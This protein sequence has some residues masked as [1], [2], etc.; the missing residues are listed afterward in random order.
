MRLFQNSGVHSSYLQRL[1]QLSPKNSGF[2]TRRRQL[3][4]DRFGALHFLKPVL[5]DDSETFFTNGDDRIL[6]Q[7]WAREHGM[8][9]G[10]NL[11]DILL[12]QIEDH[13]TE[14][15]YNTDPTR[16]DS[17]FVRRLPGCVRKTI[18]W[19]AAP[20]GSVDL[21][22][23][24][25]VVC[26]FAS[27]LEGWR[28]KGCKVAYFYPAVDPEMEGYGTSERTIDILFVGAYSR[29]HLSRVKVL[30]SVAAL[31]RDWNV[32]Y[33]LDPS[34]MTRLAESIPGR[35]IP[36]LRNLRRPK[37]IADIAKA[38]VF[39]RDLYRLIGN[40]KI[41]LNG[42]ID[43]AGDER[44]N[45]RCFEALGCGALLL[46]DDGIYPEGMKDGETMFT[47]KGPDQ[48]AGLA[49]R[50][51]SNKIDAGIVAARGRKMVGDHYNKTLQW[52][53]FVEIASLI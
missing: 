41:M 35:F 43:M 12:A 23:Y 20:S 2:A 11:G 17:S 47:Y 15:F 7:A 42:A 4:N 24:G 34:R 38:P 25:M 8:M 51:L 46:S 5:D 19:R 21:S 28:R 22:A 26:N 30:Q 29:H 18:C 1:N 14:V 44:G 50:I 52:E 31:G 9:R 27:I 6:Q 39:G 40:A 37:A 16:Y 3:L 33:C 13:R 36:Q 48:A 45:M 49:H 53:R 10:G 32:V